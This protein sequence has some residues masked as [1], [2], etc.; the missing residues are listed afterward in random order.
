MRLIIVAV[1][2]G[3]L[4]ITSE[5]Q[6]RPTLSMEKARTEFAIEV[7][8]FEIM[9]VVTTDAENRTCE[10]DDPCW[11]TTPKPLIDHDSFKY[12]TRRNRYFVRCK[13]IL[14]YDDDHRKGLRGDVIMNRY[15]RITVYL[16]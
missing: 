5:A 9:Q 13:T 1:I 14:V 6:A 11:E 2:V 10:E 12:C 15:G 4:G 3:M 8:Q 16:Y 7:M